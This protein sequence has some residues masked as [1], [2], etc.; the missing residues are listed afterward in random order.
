LHT[1]IVG[2][3]RSRSL[4]MLWENPLHYLYN[5]FSVYFYVKAKSL[6]HRLSYSWSKCHREKYSPAI[7]SEL[8]S[9]HY[10][11]LISVD[12][13][14]RLGSFDE[15][16]IFRDNVCQK[17]FLQITVPLS[18]YYYYYYYY[19]YYCCCCS[20][21]PHKGITIRNVQNSQNFSGLFP[22]S[23]IPKNT[24]FRKLDLFPSSG[25]GGGEDT[26]SLGTLRES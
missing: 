25:E 12:Q 7:S 20:F 15:V 26:Y 6:N 2:C 4:A 1:R 16:Y 24:T 5:F 23:C 8:D 17:H 9:D 22:S 14:K 18:V 11:A 21:W 19:Y 13:K 3:L 10:N